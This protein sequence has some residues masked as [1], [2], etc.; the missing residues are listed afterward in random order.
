M[1]KFLVPSQQTEQDAATYIASSI[2]W[3]RVKAKLPEEVEFSRAQFCDF[4]IA[5]NDLYS[6]AESASRPSGLSAKDVPLVRKLAMQLRAHYGAAQVFPQIYRLRADLLDLLPD[7][8]RKQNELID[9][10]EDRVRF[11][12]LSPE[13]AKLDES[14]KRY[15]AL[16][17]AR[18]A[19]PVEKGAGEST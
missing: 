10:Q 14:E 9:A 19:I 5:P 4:S 12:M 3:A 11:A 13:I 16:A 6:L 7:S 17:M 15:V 2:M 18:P 8:E 1:T